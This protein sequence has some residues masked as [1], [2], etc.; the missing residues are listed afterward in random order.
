[1]ELPLLG[2]VFAPD[3]TVKAVAGFQEWISTSARRVATRAAPVIG[4][5]LVL[6]GMIELLG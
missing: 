4:L 2:Y 1:V 5:L 6:R 3:W